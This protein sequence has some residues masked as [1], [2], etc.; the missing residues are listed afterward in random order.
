MVVAAM[1]V[2]LQGRHSMREK[3]TND[4]WAQNQ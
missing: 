4:R 3:L 2:M 1:R